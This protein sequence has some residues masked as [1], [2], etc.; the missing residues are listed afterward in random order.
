MGTLAAAKSSS[1]AQPGRVL[2]R[3][4]GSVFGRDNIVVKADYW[5]NLSLERS[6]AT[7][8]LPTSTSTPTFT[9]PEE[10]SKRSE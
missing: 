9:P 2:N 8:T 5:K 3:K 7:L 4:S 1:P 10:P 6:L